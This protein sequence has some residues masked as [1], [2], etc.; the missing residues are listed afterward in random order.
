MFD[1][2]GEFDSAEEINDSAYGLFNEG[3]FENIKVLAKENGIEECMADMFIDGEIPMLC[4]V[5]SAAIG[6]LEV[7]SE[8]LKAQEIMMDWIEYIKLQCTEDETVAR[9]VR[10]KGKSMKGCVSE[11]LKW[12]FKHMYPVDSDICKAAGVSGTVKLGI[13]GMGTA[14][15]IIKEYYLG[16]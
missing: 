4:D 10:K 14:K 3:D 8:D 5:A 9:A 13:P 11:L 15:K 7:E 2:F 16:K 6:K 12:G 1:I